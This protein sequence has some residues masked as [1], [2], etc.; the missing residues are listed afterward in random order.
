MES[1]T[2]LEKIISPTVLPLFE[3][4][5]FEKKPLLISRNDTNYFRD[6]ISIETIN[7][8]LERKDIRYPAIRLVKNGLELPQTDYLTNFPYGNKVFD[9]VI[10]NDRL[11]TLFHEGATVVFQAIHKTLPSLSAFCQR[12]EKYY[13]FPL[14]TNIYLTPRSSKGFQAHFDNHDVFVL[15]VH[16]SKVWKVYDSPVYLPTETFEKSMLP[17]NMIPQ[18]EVELKQGDTLYIP[19]GFVHEAVTANEASLHITL[20]LLTYKWIDVL[21]LIINDAHKINGFKESFRFDKLDEQTIEKT[22]KD[23]VDQLLSV[24][25]YGDIPKKFTNRFIKK[26]LTSDNNRL[27]D[28]IRFDEIN[29]G[30]IFSLRNEIS[31][32][33]TETESAIILSYYNKQVKFPVYV[34]ETLNAMAASKSFTVENLHSNIDAAGKLVLCKKLLQE[35]FL[36]I[37]DDEK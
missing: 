19:R 23:L 4:I 31:Y 20:G 28:M 12:I 15:Q 21:R 35:G 32:T 18:I 36:K 33:I 6:L 16:G 34:L 26:G 1:C 5:Y 37:N 27:L 7:K 24:V 9:N 30:T 17:K 14:Q 22:T 29:A 11:F 3:D 13:N 10:D 8:Y 2:E 25:D